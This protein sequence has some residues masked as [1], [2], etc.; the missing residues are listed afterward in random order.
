MIGRH[1]A[2]LLGACMGVSAQAFPDMV[3][4]EYGNC[5]TCHV[6]ISGG[7]VLTA[8]GRALSSEVLSMVRGSEA[9]NKALWGALPLPDWL[10]IGGDLRGMQ[11]Y[12]E[13]QKVRDGK[14][15]LMMSDV[16]LAIGN[17]A[18]VAVASAGSKAVRTDRR[19]EVEYVSRRHYLQVALDEGFYLRA[20]K[21]MK[22]FGINSPDHS[23]A[24]KRGIGF[25]HDTET[26][27]AEVAYLDEQL[28]LSITAVFG[29]PNDDKLKD[30]IEKGATASASWLI[31]DRYKLGVSVF[32]GESASSSRRIGGAWVIAGVTRRFYVLL[33]HD[34]TQTWS[35]SD[36][37][38]DPMT[39]FAT[40]AREGFEL[41]RGLHLYL[42]EE[43]VKQ[44][45]AQ[46][47]GSFEGFGP[48]ITWYPRPHFEVSL[49][50][51]AQ[52]LSPQQSTLSDFAWL[53]THVYL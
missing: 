53:M 24:T 33:E 31:D 30:V 34:V 15:F 28:N 32:Q 19:D 36:R 22:S 44:S 10:A 12:R 3:R 35:K 13:D 49:Q 45:V 48:G 11:T 39:G 27:N 40:S 14:Y 21:Y 51:Q 8:Y 50:Y 26:Y 16:E 17:A 1:S 20:G 18:I 4:H 29:R 37:N 52:R 38:G 9:E 25:D 23:S 5:A 2:L 46:K 7:G 47:K 42:A 6:S 43:V 41:T